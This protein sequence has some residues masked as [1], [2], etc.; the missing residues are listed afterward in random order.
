MLINPN[1]GWTKFVGLLLTNLEKNMDGNI[2]TVLRMKLIVTQA[3]IS[4]EEKNKID[5]SEHFKM[6]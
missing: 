3:N 1:V 5:L 6:F 2:K 4:K